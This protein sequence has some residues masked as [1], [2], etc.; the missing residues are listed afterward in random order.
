ME[1]LS[2]LVG[3]K[4]REDFYLKNFKHSLMA[5]GRIHLYNIYSRDE[6]PAPGTGR[7]AQESEP[8]VFRMDET[9]HRIVFDL[10]LNKSNTFLVPEDM[11]LR[12]N[13]LRTH[14][15]HIYYI[16]RQGVLEPTNERIKNIDSLFE[17]LHT[18]TV[19]IIN[20]YLLHAFEE[21]EKSEREKDTSETLT[22]DSDW[23]ISWLTGNV[24]LSKSINEYYQLLPKGIKEDVLEDERKDVLNPIGKLRFMKHFSHNILYVLHCIR[25]RFRYREKIFREQEG[26][27]KAKDGITPSSSP[28][29]DRSFKRPPFAD[30]P[31]EPEDSLTAA[32]L[33]IMSEYAYRE[34]GVHRELQIFERLL[35]Q[36]KAELNL[37]SSSA[38]Y[39]D[40]LYHVL[41]VCLLGELLLRS[42]LT[43]EKSS[44]PGNRFQIFGATLEIS[45][46]EN[47]LRNWYIAALCHDIGYTVEKTEKFIQPV[48]G[49]RSSILKE[50]SEEL[51]KGITAGKE[52]ILDAFLRIID[53][54][55]HLIKE[56]LIRKLIDEK[57]PVDH[58]AAAWLELRK[59]IKDTEISKNEIDLTPALTAILRHNLAGQEIKI[60]DE[61]LSFLLML[62]DH[63][64]EWGRPRVGPAPLS[65]GIMEGLRFSKEPQFERKIRMSR[66]E[67]NGLK[68]SRVHSG[69]ISQNCRRCIWFVEGKLKCRKVCY[70]FQTEIADNKRGVTFTL[71]HTEAREAD[72]EPCISWLM[73]CRD[74]QS[75][76]FESIA[77]PFPITVVLKHPP[78]RIWNQ[79]SWKPMEMDIFHEYAET[80]EH[81][82]YLCQWIEY[83]KNGEKGI[84]YRCNRANENLIDTGGLKPGE[85][86]F[87]I[88]LHE[89][90]KPLTRTLS[91]QHWEP[92]FDWKW[93]WIKRKYTALTL[94]TLIPDR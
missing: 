42:L 23:L 94:G 9:S 84:E 79:L 48:K 73:F 3:P 43:K 6:F 65:S 28:D 76:Q 22:I 74:L 13:W 75:I 44:G 37:Y 90:G 63:L 81:A 50:F 10:S 54:G 17:E 57:L 58:G 21:S 29:T 32:Q 4:K 89:L 16:A 45:G 52:K 34:I 93:D 24:L 19:D 60:S 5:L 83:A 68:P 47:I 88:R 92:F 8:N 53:D 38:I 30:V 1:N 71:P 25:F 31:P 36:L 59:W 55:D 35:R 46:F 67:I 72:F 33:Y 51:D 86:S 11:E 12:L 49:F 41:D 62:C 14:W 18:R 66:I 69:G 26:S 64:Q 39:R 40:H 77:V 87:T 80:Q 70:R 91:P 7:G 56:Q 27:T 20:Y 82:T 2:N 78:S 61:P 85:E 15:L